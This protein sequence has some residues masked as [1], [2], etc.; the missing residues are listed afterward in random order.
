MTIG[1]NESVDMDLNQHWKKNLRAMKK[2]QKSY[3]NNNHHTGGQSGR[4]GRGGGRY[5]QRGRG[6]GGSARYNGRSRSDYGDYNNNNNNNN[7]HHIVQASTTTDDGRLNVYALA[8]YLRH[9][10]LKAHEE[11]LDRLEQEALESD[12]KAVSSQDSNAKV[13]SSDRNTRPHRQRWDKGSKEEQQRRRKVWLMHRLNTGLAITV[14]ICLLSFVMYSYSR[15]ISSNKSSYQWPG[16]SLFKQGAAAA[17]K[18]ARK[19]KRQSS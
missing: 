8:K 5:H 11:R 10:E 17:A 15:L 19:M 7:D 2:K 3:S 6:R 16:F 18:Y 9:A 13:V 12:D 1:R 14:T 4:R